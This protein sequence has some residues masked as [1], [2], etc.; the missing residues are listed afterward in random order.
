[1][2]DIG[3]AVPNEIIKHFPYDT[4]LFVLGK[5]F[6]IINQKANESFNESNMCFIAKKLSLNLTKTYYMVFTANCDDNVELYC[7]HRIIHKVDN[8][9]Y[10]GVLID[11][12]LKW[13]LLIEQ[14][15]CKLIK[16]TS[17]FYKLRT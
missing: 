15:Y 12:K 5:S 6:S 13:T 1:V 9:H 4:N 3:N 17:I 16:F 2:N 10:L 7:G 14:L 11:H 8:Y